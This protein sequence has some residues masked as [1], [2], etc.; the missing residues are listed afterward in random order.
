MGKTNRKIAFH[1][2]G[3]YSTGVSRIIIN[4]SNYLAKQG[5]QVDIVVN[6]RSGKLIADILPEVR[7][8]NLNASRIR[9]AFGLPQLVQYLSSEE[10]DVLLATTHYSSERAILAK[11]LAKVST[12]VVIREANTLSLET[13][14]ETQFRHRLK[15]LT[16]KLTYSRADLIIA[17]SKAVAKDLSQITKI[18][19]DKIR[20]IYNPTITPQLFKKAKEALE[21]PWFQYGQP[22]VI[23]G[24]GRLTRQKD[25]PTL[26][27][28]F[29]KVRKVREARL[30]ILGEGRSSLDKEISSTI[31]ELGLE[32]YVSLAGFQQNPYPYIA[33]A[34][35]FVL[36]SRF[37]G[38]PNVL[39]EAMALKTP[40]ISTDCPGGS[41]EILNEGQYGEL[42]P[43]GDSDLIA[44]AILK[45]LSGNTKKVDSDWLNQFSLQV[46]APQYLKALQVIQ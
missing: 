35:V 14:N 38:L 32:D 31:R 18:P 17:V 30:M 26:I 46:A 9:E 5:Y 11:I 22:P 33:Q 15:L 27:R 1:I 12:K 6:Y 29:N 36:S 39:I 21:H 4:L 20:V 19:L 23:L 13:K 44:K 8:V 28:A 2:H 43:V 3:I 41:A 34:S 37:E 7:I 25:F 42:V 10:P 40:V 45:V 24:I 16:T